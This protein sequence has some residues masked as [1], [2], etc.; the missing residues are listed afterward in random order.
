MASAAV[1]LF[2]LA[3]GYWWTAEDSGKPVG[4]YS[5]ADQ[6][7][8]PAAEQAESVVATE[9]DEA[10]RVEP[11]QVTAVAV[12]G[13]QRQQAAQA[14]Q[15][16][17]PRVRGTPVASGEP[18]EDR[19]KPASAPA[20]EEHNRD[21]PHMSASQMGGIYVEQE[22]LGLPSKQKELGL[23]WASKDGRFSL[24]PWL[25]LQVRYS[26][27]FDSAP[28][29]NNDFSNEPGGE[30]EIKR[31]RL[32][33]DGY[34]FDP[35][36]SIY[37]E[38]SLTSGLPL[39]DLRLDVALSDT[40]FLRIG[41]YKV[42]Y[43][44]E[45]IDSSGKQQFV[46]RSIS[47]Y[48]FT[49]DRQRGVTLSKHWLEGTRFDNWL[50]L[51]V[52]QGSGRGGGQHGQQPMAVGRW[53]W[54]FLGEAV[55]FSQSDFNFSVDPAASLA[56][57]HSHVRGPYTRFSTD[58]GGQLDG[59]SEGGDERYTLSQ[60]LQEFV[61]KYRG[62]SLQQEYHIKYI[63]DHEGADDGRLQGGYMQAGKAWQ[64]GLVDF[65]VEIALRYSRVDWHTNQPRIQ[66]EFTVAMNLFFKGHNSKL[67]MDVSRIDL[68][69]D[70]LQDSGN[71]LRLQWDLSF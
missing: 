34:L 61:Y 23:V 35:A 42:L 57:A 60:W 33:L 49:I 70:G 21:L 2:L 53:Q 58:G 7:R 28:V 25:R 50:M 3:A 43:N 56:F 26:N 55:P 69:M 71:R 36:F 12:S 10:E 1:L 27:P 63:D 44:R 13:N 52:F 67:T 39:L 37:Y 38:Q 6:S 65:P 64:P 32:K 46:D 17:R 19:L 68:D 15:E 47:N 9:S 66:Q 45:R 40:W 48:G 8:R 4:N 31:A 51:G 20:P 18:H 30:L 11:V 5:P 62:Y 54:Q 16:I 29:N 24:N 22:G 59:F 14:S 41:Q